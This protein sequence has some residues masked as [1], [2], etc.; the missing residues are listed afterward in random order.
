MTTPA[1]G[2]ELPRN[3]L[4]DAGADGPEFDLRQI[5][6]AL[7]RYKWTLSGFSKDVT[8][9]LATGVPGKGDHS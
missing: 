4:H 1:R 9:A 6:A 2:I 7:N 8:L 5:L 3:D